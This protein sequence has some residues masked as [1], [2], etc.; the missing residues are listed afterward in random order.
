[1]PEM[2]LRA[3]TFKVRFLGWLGMTTERQYVV[4]S[5]NVILNEVKGLDRVSL[6]QNRSYDGLISKSR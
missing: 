1:M 6:L 4:N 2:D 3:N 5:M